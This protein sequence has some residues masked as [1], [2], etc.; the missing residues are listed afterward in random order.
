VVKDGGLP[1]G[2][3]VG[4][5]VVSLPAPDGPADEPAP[6]SAPDCGSGV[7]AVGG[8]WASDP[9]CESED[10]LGELGVVPSGGEP[11]GVVPFAGGVPVGE[12]PA[13]ATTHCE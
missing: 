2:L 6:G 12:A 10:P 4:A 11:S 3:A 9:G 1:P 5:A 8:G 7:V 13:G